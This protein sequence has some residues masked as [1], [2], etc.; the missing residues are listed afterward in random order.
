MFRHARHALLV[1]LTLGLLAAGVSPSWAAPGRGGTARKGAVSQAVSTRSAADLPKPPKAMTLAQRR[2]QVAR[3]QGKFSPMRGYVRPRPVKAALHPHARP[4]AR[5]G[6]GPAGVQRPYSGGTVAPRS[7]AAVP[8]PAWVSAYATAYPGYM[9]IGGNLQFGSGTASSY[10]GMWLYVIDSSGNYVIQ[11][12]IKRSTGDPSGRFLETGAWCYGWWAANSYPANQCFWWASNKPGGA[13]QDGKQY[14]AWIFMEG[15]D[16]ST[17]P[18]GTTSPYVTAFYTP[19]IPG[20]QVGICTCYAQTD[21]A[22]PVNTATGTYF[23]KATDARLTGAGK[24]LTLDRYYRSDSSATGLLGRGWST[25]FDS[26]LTLTANDATLLTADGSRVS[27]LK[28][29]DGTY[30]THVGAFLKLTVSGSAYT[31]TDQDHSASVFDSSGRLTALRDAGGH[32]L[33]LSYTSG[34]LA[35]VTDAAGRS[36]AFSVGSDGLLTKITLPDATTVGYG[37]TS[38]LLTSATDPAGK[39]TAPATA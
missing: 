22:D 20:S 7:A 10:S 21:R 32:G 19:D 17:S 37:Y 39:T 14:Y 27:F 3:D 36:T 16:G 15:T 31:V 8:D 9:S 30:A 34:H 33:S 18:S 2:V 26:K 13:L 38:G 6:K 11:Q 1:I 35:S 24:P 5:P 25:P 23:E 4:S 28:L 29:S 12:E